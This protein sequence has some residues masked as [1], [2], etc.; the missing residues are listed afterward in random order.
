MVMVLHKYKT[1]YVTL[2]LIIFYKFLKIINVDKV[3][4]NNIKYK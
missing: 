3:I 2:D 4:H 1:Y